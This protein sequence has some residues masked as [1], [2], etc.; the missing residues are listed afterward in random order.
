MS[1]GVH[2]IWYL[3]G[4]QLLVYG[5]IVTGTGVWELFY[6]PTHHVDLEWMHPAIWWGALMFCI[7][8][9]YVTRFHDLIMGKKD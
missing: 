5:V 6:P 3:I 1:K 9:Y 7:G 8:L 4:L 2:S